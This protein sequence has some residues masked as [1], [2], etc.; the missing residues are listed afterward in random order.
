MR[1]GAKRWGRDK[2]DDIDFTLDGVED[3][4][5]RQMN[6][7]KLDQKS[8]LEQR[9]KSVPLRRIL[10]KQERSHGGWLRRSD[11]AGCN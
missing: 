1:R 8:V 6:L 5:T 11:R 4:T 9:I 3:G 10:R 2:V 7:D